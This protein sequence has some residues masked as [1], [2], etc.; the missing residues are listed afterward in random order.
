MDHQRRRSLIERYADGPRVVA[1][2]VAG[3]SDA[4]LDEPPADGGWTVREVVHHLA[5][6]EMTS[7]VRLR[8]LLA[9]DAPRIDAYDEERFAAVL[10]YRDRPVQAALAAVA[11]ARQTSRELLD[12]LTEADWARAGTHSTSG[13][14]SV[15]D[16]LEIYAAH[17]HDHADQIRAPR[18]GAASS[19]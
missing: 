16:W 11:A 1:E 5:D 8:R 14:Y 4:Q 10:H 9:E 3:L 7:A 2:A 17:A 6:S 13:R 19:R 15:D 12:R 18:T